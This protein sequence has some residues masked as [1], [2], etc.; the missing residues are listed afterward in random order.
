MD[1]DHIT[2][3]SDISAIESTLVCNVNSDAIGL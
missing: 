2:V 3:F 1:F